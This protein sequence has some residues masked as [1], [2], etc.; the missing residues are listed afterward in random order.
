MIKLIYAVV[1]S[2]LV[3][4]KLLS[5]FFSD[6]DRTFIAMSSGSNL[7]IDGPDNEKDLLHE[8]QLLLSNSNDQ[9]SDLFSNMKIVA[10]VS[11]KKSLFKVS[12]FFLNS[13][14]FFRQR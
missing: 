6:L 14:T 5:I 8:T 3:F 12:A 1:L 7:P 9:G 11:G 4:V 2:N 13:N 10:Y